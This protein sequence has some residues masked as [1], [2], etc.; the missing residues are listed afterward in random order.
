MTHSS[1]AAE[2]VICPLC[3]G[4]GEVPKPILAARWED[5]EIQRILAQYSDECSAGTGGGMANP[6]ESREEATA[7][8]TKQFHS[9]GD[10]VPKE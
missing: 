9:R 4:H 7:G 8:S 3:Q 10:G 6:F 5:R 1:K 2:I